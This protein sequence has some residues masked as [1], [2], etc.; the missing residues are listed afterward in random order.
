MA[1]A[2]AA[3]TAVSGT[4]GVFA[5]P[6]AASIASDRKLAAHLYNRLQT[7]SAKV[8][9]LGQKFDAAQLKVD[10]EDALINNTRQV[11]L[12]DESRVA[13][14]Q[15]TLRNVAIAAYVDAGSTAS[16]NPLFSQNDATAGAAS[17]YSQ[18]A[19][20]NLASSVATLK[21]N[22]LEL[23]QERQIL[24][25]QYHEAAQAAKVAAAAFHRAQGLENTVHAMMASV[26]S[27]IQ[28][29]VTQAQQAAADAAAAAWERQNPGSPPYSGSY[30]NFPVPPPDSK[31]DI[32]V[33]TALSYLGVPYVWGGAS[34]SG[35]DCSG[36][37]MLAW[38]AAGVYLPHYSG[39]QYAETVHI[40]LADIEPGDLLFYGYD[41]DQH[42]AMYIGR[43]LMIEAPETG[44]VVH[45][46]PIRTGYDFWG[47]GRVR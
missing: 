28:A 12:E 10:A 1:L 5:R 6:A 9:Y 23:T 31:A 42:V 14:D 22:S 41:G 21:A 43:G 32:A 2:L 13:T 29:F 25:H 24:R 20:G 47:V 17:V 39:A 16:T 3:V 4:V 8:S 45:I 37:V 38:A 18:L 46:T 30:A 33:A 34:R 19:E 26:N 36:L 44:Q 11:V 7:L 15:V 27:Q 35:V 40:P